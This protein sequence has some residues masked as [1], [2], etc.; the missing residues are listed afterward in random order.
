MMRTSLRFAATAALVGAAAAQA[1]QSFRPLSS[2]GVVG[3]IAEIVS[4]TGNGNTLAFSDADAGRIGLLDITD[5]AQPVTLT[6]VPTGAG[7]EPTSV[8]VSGN[9][10][11]GAV[12]TS[13]FGEDE[14]P[15][16]T[17]NQSELL[18]AD[19]SDP[20]N[21]AVLG[22]V[23][24]GFQPD[25]VKLLDL[26]GQL[27]AVV[28]IENEPIIVDP[29]SGLI[30][31][32]D[33]PG[34][35]N[36]VSL[37]GLVQVVSL[38]LTNVAGSTVVD[39]PLP[40][41]DL[42]AA[43]CDFPS[44]PQPE[45][46]DVR[47]TTAVVSLQ[48]NNGIAV[49]DL[50]DPLQPSLVRI[51]NT[52]VKANQQADLTEDD[53][54]SLT[55]TYPA[56]VMGLVDGGGNPATPGTRNPDAIAL[57][58]AGTVIFSADEGELNFTGGRGASAW[59]LQGNLL[60]DSG[61]LLEQLAV[62]L[63]QYPEGRSENRGIEIEGVT[64]GVFG[65]REYAFFLS[66]RGSWVAVF[67]IDNPAR[68][69]LNN[70]LPTGI[71]PEGVVA[72]PQRGLFAT[73]DEESGT[74]TIF[75]AMPG[76]RRPSRSQ[77]VIYG[78]GTPWGAL[79]GTDGGAFGFLVA[80]PDN[81]L[82][83]SI[84]AIGTGLPYAPLFKLA[85]VTIGGVQQRYDLEGIARDDSILASRR[86]WNRGWWLANEGRASDGLP[87]LLVQVDNRGRV[88]CEIQ[89]PNA[90]DPAA[91]ASLP[92]TT[93]GPS[94]AGTIRNNGFEG[95]TI[96]PD[97]RYLYAAIQRD[98]R[99]EDEDAA[100]NPA[101]RR[102]ARIARYDLRQLTGPMANTLTNGIRA[103]GDWDFFFYEVDNAST[104]NQVGL[105]EIT[106]VGRGRFLVIERDSEIGAASL[107]KKIYTFDLDG[108]VPD[109][110]GIPDATDTVTKVEIADVLAEFFPYEKVECLAVSRGKLW[111]GLDNDGGEVENRF[112]NLGRLRDLLPSKPGNGWRR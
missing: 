18:V 97:G 56:D 44:D 57:N 9:I 68:P 59:D 92:G 108:L 109:T 69:V 35:P 40:A 30:V 75:D 33:L 2:T 45:F 107:L 6:G 90:I 96:S 49:I 22:T 1:P 54:I 60:W 98:F 41:A 8:S 89:L 70:V 25:S 10:A 105:S 99:G 43:G 51:F 87:N 61:A 111:V 16:S 11:V 24:I 58:D 14:V 53:A 77:P 86:F 48:E 20:R 67:N 12:F 95:V 4:V 46:A 31:D 106:N 52:G 91:D 19:I 5:P 47:G 71:S 83:S 29:A 17:S 50:A 42:A 85:D 73:A 93:S 65:G 103:G 28:C 66:E 23:K 84:F 34:N 37:P 100:G 36:D 94:R 81:A 101:T 7:T 72:I 76:F 26:N 63:G 32:D 82:P 21:P 78:V 79:S 39:V 55:E 27:V 104:D 80:V 15:P 62:V 88:L 38:D 110:D 3:G 74:L 102:F 13:P 112:I 64:T